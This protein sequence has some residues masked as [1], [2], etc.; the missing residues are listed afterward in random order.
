MNKADLQEQLQDLKD[1][2]DELK[3]YSADSLDYNSEEVKKELASNAKRIAQLEAQIK[4][5]D[6]NAI[7]PGTENLVQLKVSF[8]NRFSARTGKE[9]NKPQP[10]CFSYGEWQLFKESYE[11]LGYQI[12]EVIN[13]PYGDAAELVSQD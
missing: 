10:V 12:T 8:G 7:E 6:E 2:Q 4:A 13:D 11:R 3:Q 1:R 5:L 9:I